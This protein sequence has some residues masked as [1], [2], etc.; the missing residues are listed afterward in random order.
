MNANTKR[1]LTILANM[2][3][4]NLDGTF[5][6]FQGAARP[7]GIVMCPSGISRTETP[8]ILWSYDIEDAS[9]ECPVLQGYPCGST[10]RIKQILSVE[11]V[12]DGYI[13]SVLMNIE[14][15]CT[16]GFNKDLHPTREIRLWFRYFGRGS[17]WTLRGVTMFGRPGLPS[18]STNQAN[19]LSI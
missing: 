12:R 17:A 5:V 9:E 14:V 10:A 7:T 2:I 13:S 18:P 4:R 16:A 6:L 19:G 1:Q 3:Q 15:Y 8:D 11:L